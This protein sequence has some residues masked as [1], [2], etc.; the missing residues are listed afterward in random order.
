MPKKSTAKKSAGTTSKPAAK[1]SKNTKS[2]SAIK[3]QTKTAIDSDIRSFET[4]S[5]SDAPAGAPRVRIHR[6]TL[7]IASVIILLG[8]L[9]YFGRSFFV[10]AVVNGQPITRLELAQEAEKAVGKQTMTTLI[11]NILVNQ[12][13]QKQKIT[14]SDKEVSDQIK[15]I[16]QNLSKQGQKLDQM[17]SLEGMTRDDLNRIIHQDLLVTKLIGKDIKV[18]EKE[19]NEFIEQNKDQLPKDKKGNDLKKYVEDQLKKAQLPQKAQA[20]FADVEKK[21]SIIKFVNY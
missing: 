6:S 9:L 15:T 8:L 5:V 19:V 21:A 10:A 1:K 2:S 17:L 14:V 13:A 4:K 20:W 3:E 16:E 7:I 11:R 18:S 12:E